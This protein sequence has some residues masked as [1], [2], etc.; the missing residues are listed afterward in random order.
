[1]GTCGPNRIRNPV[2]NY[3]AALEV[4]GRTSFT[5]A[6][7]EK[8]QPEHQGDEMHEEMK[9]SGILVRPAKTAAKG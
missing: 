6:G 5:N 4:I 8:V 9:L 2:V 1:M 7:K 3:A